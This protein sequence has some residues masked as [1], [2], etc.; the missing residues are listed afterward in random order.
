MKKIISKYLF[1]LLFTV[2]CILLLNSSILLILN[3]LFENF[4]SVFE[5]EFM[6]VVVSITFIVSLLSLILFCVLKYKVKLA[7]FISLKKFSLIYLF[8]PIAFIIFFLIGLT[9]S[10]YPNSLSIDDLKMLI[11]FLNMFELLFLSI[12]SNL[13]I[14][15]LNQTSEES[16]QSIKLLNFAVLMIILNVTFVIFANGAVREC[17]IPKQDPTWFTYAFFVLF[18]FI[19]IFSLVYFI[20]YVVRNKNIFN[21]FIFIPLVVATFL[22]YLTQI[23]ISYLLVIVNISWGNFIPLINTDILILSIVLV[24]VLLSIQQFFSSFRKVVENR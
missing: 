17:L 14:Y 3:S 15:R 18:I 4:F 10:Q 1:N 9:V 13:I 23:V 22:S 21:L 8:F 11:L 7:L 19:N 6:L 20:I 12:M 5:N 2:V 24:T 16:N